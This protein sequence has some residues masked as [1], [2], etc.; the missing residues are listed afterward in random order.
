MLSSI[1]VKVLLRQL[2][3]LLSDSSD[4]EAFPLQTTILYKG[5]NVGWFQW[6]IFR[7]FEKKIIVLHICDLLHILETCSF[8]GNLHFHGH[9]SFF[10]KDFQMLLAVHIGNVAPYRALDQI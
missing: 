8:M 1:Y 6:S 9:H 4:F 7:I 2:N 10:R 3:V 5:Y